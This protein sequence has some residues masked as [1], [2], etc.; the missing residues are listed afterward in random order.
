MKEIIIGFDAR[1]SLYVIDKN[2][3]SIDSSCLWES[4]AEQKYNELTSGEKLS[5]Q[6]SKKSGLGVNLPFWADLSK[7]EDFVKLHYKK[8]DKGYSFYAITAFKEEM[9][10]RRGWPYLQG[11]VP[12]K[13]SPD[14]KLIGYDVFIEND[15]SIFAS[16]PKIKIQDGLLNQYFLFKDRDAANTYRITQNLGESYILGIWKCLCLS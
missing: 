4:L 8:P 11:T 12:S 10:N 9:E 13:L 15:E 6:S 2:L 1:C 7:L 16:M 3:I 14:W 5:L